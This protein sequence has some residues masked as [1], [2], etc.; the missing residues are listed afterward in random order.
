MTALNDQE[1]PHDGLEELGQCALCGSSKRTQL[2][3]KLWDKVF[4]VAPGTWQMWR[5][6]SC[7]SGYLD[8]RPTEWTIGWAYGIYYTHADAPELPPLTALGRI[9]NGLA[10]GYRN[11]RFGTR[12]RPELKAGRLLGLLLPPL[13]WE[14]DLIYRFLP[15]RQLDDAG[16]LL[17]IGCGNGAYLQLARAAGWKVAGTDPD[18]VARER[19]A[20]KGLTVLESTEDWLQRPDRFDFITLSHV[21]EHVHDPVALLRQAFAL[22]RPGGQIYL[23]TP[24]IDAY[25]HRFYGSDWRGLEPPRHL[26][27]FN[28]N[29]L[30]D[31]LER[32]GFVGLKD[33]LHN[34]LFYFGRQFRSKN[35]GFGPADT[36][37]RNAPKPTLLDRFRSSVSYTAAEML[38][39]IAAKPRCE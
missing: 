37:D 38:T 34:R 29:S 11:N 2:H 27:I 31:A 19:G 18:P 20:E 8:P 14:V 28:R 36:T 7:R 23:Q 22:L 35:I 25:G 12:F 21:I 24:N 15:H 3:A 33:A 13:T 30:H 17:D 39:V 6:V 5:C 10:N 26:I 9:R 4:K 16:S 1:W 32:A